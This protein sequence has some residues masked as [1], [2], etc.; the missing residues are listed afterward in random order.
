MKTVHWQWICFPTG[1][2][3]LALTRKLISTVPIRFF[4]Q[5]FNCIL[6]NYLLFFLHFVL[7]GP[8]GVFDLKKNFAL[9][10]L[11]ERLH[12]SETTE[13]FSPSFI[14][15]ERELAVPCDENETHLVSETDLEVFRFFDLA[16]LNYL[17]IRSKVGTCV[18]WNYSH[19]E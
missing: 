19:S 14:E 4:K 6:L 18:Q 11:I 13:I 15:R 10:E 5:W 9:I 12:A 3:L 8:N 2:E 1:L 16:K 17:I 7:L